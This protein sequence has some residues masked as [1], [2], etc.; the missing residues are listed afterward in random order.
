M[1][2]AALTVTGAARCDGGKRAMA[3]FGEADDAKDG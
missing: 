3:A 2:V 1:A